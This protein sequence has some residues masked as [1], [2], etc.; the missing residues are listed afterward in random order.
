MIQGEKMGSSD[1][2]LSIKTSSDIINE[3]YYKMNQYKEYLIFN[4]VRYNDKI[5]LECY[6]DNMIITSKFL[7]DIIS[8]I[9]ANSNEIVLETIEYSQ[10][11]DFKSELQLFDWLYEIYKNK[12]DGYYKDLGCLIIPSKNYYKNRIKLRKHY[13][14]YNGVDDE[15]K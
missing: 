6:F 5:E 9:K 8:S 2:Y 10:I 11:F 3:I 12:I 1:F 13:K 14:K 15:E 7:Y 4:Y